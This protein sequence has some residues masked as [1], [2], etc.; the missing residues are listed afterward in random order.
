[1]LAADKIILNKHK[2]AK[3]SPE[4]VYATP[5]AGRADKSKLA[6]S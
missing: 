3:L 2:S 6:K 4:H 1:M 5:F